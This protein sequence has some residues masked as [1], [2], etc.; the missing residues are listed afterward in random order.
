MKKQTL[1]LAACGVLA[2]ASCNNNPAPVEGGMSQEKIDSIVNA[3]VDA[4]RTELMAQND[5]IINALAT[6]KADSIVASM[7]PGA[8]MPAKPKPVVKAPGVH[9]SEPLNVQPAKPGAGDVNNRPGAT[10]NSGQSVSDRPGATNNSGNKPVN[11]RP[12]A[13]NQN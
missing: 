6:W 9:R 13:T 2:L 4:I 5:S 3:R 8:P 7:K 11:D 12:G 1:L 10:N